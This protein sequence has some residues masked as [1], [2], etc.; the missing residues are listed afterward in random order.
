MND[1]ATDKQIG[2][3]SA[4]IVEREIPDEAREQLSARIAARDITKRR[5]SDFIER[6][7]AKPARASAHIHVEYETGPALE[8]GVE[9]VGYVVGAGPHRVPRGRYALDTS[10]N[11]T[12]HN[13]VTFFKLWVGKRG[14]WGLDIQASDEEY[15]VDNWNTKMSVVRAIAADPEGAMRRYGRELGSC[16]MCGRTLTNDVS[17]ELGIGPICRERL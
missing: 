12:F 9:R 11:P 10:G 13:D 1:P 16:G 14:G 8:S 5:A 4:L 7:L 6:L 3:L 17:R 2:L 15:K